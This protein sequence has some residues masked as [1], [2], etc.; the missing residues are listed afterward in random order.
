MIIV[1]S[2]IMDAK[3]L[4]AHRGDNTNYPENSSIGIKAALDAGALFIEF[5]VQMNADKT[6]I[7]LHDTNFKRTADLDQSVFDTP[8]SQIKNISI[9]EPK[10][11][12]KQHYPTVLSTLSDMMM[13]LISQH[14]KVTVFVEIKEES[15]DHFGL[16]IVMDQLLTDLKPY[17]LQA[18]V[19]SFSSE[20]IEYA[21]EKN[22]HLK[23]GWVLEKY[24]DDYRQ[25]AIKL[26]PD[27]LFCNYKKMSNKVLWEGDWQW[28]VYTVNT[29]DVAKQQLDK[30]IDLVETD[31]IGLLLRTQD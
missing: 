29:I 1:Y 10:R 15:L 12:A 26:S 31:D 3:R 16:E 28:A 17:T 13:M 4:V 6:L 2:R 24:N 8:D 20:A 9:H 23:I 25:R 5:D 22:N 21:Q 19:I 7:V 11:F 27:Y 18:V 30:G 14:P